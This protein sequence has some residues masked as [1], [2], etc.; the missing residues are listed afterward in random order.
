[1]F[2]GDLGGGRGVG[3]KKDLSDNRQDKTRERSSI[4]EI[5]VSGKK[6]I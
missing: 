6:D 3:K 2:S 4:R 5:R 1:M